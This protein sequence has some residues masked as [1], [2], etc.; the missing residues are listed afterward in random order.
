MVVNAVVARRVDT[1][2]R[3]CLLEAQNELENALLWDV[4]TSTETTTTKKRLSSATKRL[5]ELAFV[6]RLRDETCFA[7]AKDALSGQHQED[8]Q[9]LKMVQ[10]RF[11]VQ[12][13]AFVEH[14][15]LS[16]VGSKNSVRA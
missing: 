16:R 6:I 12:L 3:G 9:V 13:R 14:R 2:V 15:S 4:A 1:A 7:A 10:A 5:L 8:V 11:R